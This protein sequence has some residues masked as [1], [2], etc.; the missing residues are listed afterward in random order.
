MSA[1]SLSTR[2]ALPA[3]IAWA[4]FN[5]L[6]LLF[7]L[8][9]TA[10]WISLALL[11]RVATAGQRWPLRMASRLWAPGLLHG[12]GAR[13][14]VEGADQVD[15][16]RPCVLVANH[17]SVIDVCALFRAVPIPL[18]F[19]LKQEMTR[20]P[21]VG[22]YAKAM[23]MVF[24]DRGNA[25][26]SRSRLLAVADG[27]RGGATVCAFPEGTRSVDGSVGPFKG[28]PFQLALAAG[29]PVLPV[30]LDGS[31]AVLPR[32]GFAV[33]PGV[34]RVRFGTPIETAGLG[35]DERQA[36]A[37]RARDAVIALKARPAGTDA[38]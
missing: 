38:A 19:V 26:E 23:G 3:R 25:R 28:G 10:A 17:Q 6:Q 9:W 35:A 36:L 24:I 37:R 34:I 11:V 20:V 2:P 21:F 16:S 8:A 30:A 1:T 12:A 15:W 33:R 27:V 29:A 32:A 5:A 18:R 4:C 14:V 13:L 31:G 7:T 22:W